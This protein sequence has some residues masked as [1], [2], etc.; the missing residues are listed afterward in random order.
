[1]EKLERG[2]RLEPWESGAL[3]RP[4]VATCCSMR[5]DPGPQ[6]ATNFLLRA[7]AGNPPDGRN[8]VR[9]ADAYQQLGD[10]YKAEAALRTGLA[11][12][13]NLPDTAWRLANFLL[14][15]GRP[16]SLPAPADGGLLGS[17]SPS[18]DI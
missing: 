14:L 3:D 1:M 5:P 12:G 2:L 11:A 4:T 10:S 15:R 6:K 17:K 8:W 16:Q 13:P 9:L 18:C 7:A